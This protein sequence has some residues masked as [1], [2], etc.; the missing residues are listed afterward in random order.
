VPQIL[1]GHSLK[2]LRNGAEYF[3]ELIEAIDESQEL[4]RLETYIFDFNEAH[5]LASIAVARALVRAGLRGVAVFVTMDGVGTG[6]VPPYWQQQ[7]DAANVQWRIYSPFGLSGYFQP[8]RWRR[9]HRKLCIVDPGGAHSTAFCGGINL[10]D[11]F[12]D[13]NHGVLDKPR[14]DFAV[15]VR[16][17]LGAAVN[18]AMQASWALATAGHS[19]R[20]ARVGNAVSAFKASR[21]RQFDASDFEDALRSKSGGARAA[22]LLRD[23]LRHRMRI[24]RSYLK[25]VGGAHQEVIIAN[26]YFLPG[27]KLRKAL[28]L[29]ARR[30]VQVSLLLQGKY[31]YFM[32]WHAA[33]PVYSMLLEAGVRIYEYEA[34][35]LH[36]KVA[37]VD[38]HGDKPWATVGSS[39]LD[40]L[41]LLM[42]REANVVVEDADFAKTLRASLRNAIETEGDEVNADAFANRGVW[43]RF[44]N[45]LAY[46]VMRASLWMLGKRY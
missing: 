30:G 14:F 45:W 39:N 46:G 8:S 7:F 1:P 38:A 12:Y 26:A 34:S 21:V 29:A 11:D 37:V 6:E 35:F 15:R 18:D 33:R 17:P 4:V 32:Q 25:A 16:G 2:L 44:L 27:R 9:L 40:P 20:R 23:N 13:P 36:A 3:A 31:E 19:L 28:I 43:E 42:A 41:S 10:L 5:G 24:E 22:L